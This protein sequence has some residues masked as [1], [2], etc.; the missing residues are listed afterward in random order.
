V[1]R[2]PRFARR[3]LSVALATATG[4]AMLA[5][6][7]PAYA[8]GGD[9]PT[10]VTVGHTSTCLPDGERQ[11][12]WSVSTNSESDSTIS[13]V[14][15]ASAPTNTGF[16]NG[17]IIKVGATLPGSPSSLSDK[18]LMPGTN[19]SASLA[20]TSIFGDGEL[21]TPVKG[22][23]EATFEPC[24]PWYTV[25]QDCTGI[26]FV[27]GPPPVGDAV[28]HVTL[29]PSVGADQS[30]NMTSGEADKTVTFPG[31]PGLTVD[32]SYGEGFK[33]SYAWDHAP[34]PTLPTTGTRIGGTIGTGAGLVVG[35]VLLLLALVWLRRRRAVSGS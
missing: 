7:A 23:D 35:G 27:I 8:H 1:K 15:L 25:T 19:T 12:I 6:A 28:F 20:V 33:K 3:A 18:Q 5:L 29:H 2:F 16:V 4:A 22:S 10:V 21:A 26:T 11:V 9:N 14:D 17:N 24:T 31:S 13:K 34:C 30:F 32:L